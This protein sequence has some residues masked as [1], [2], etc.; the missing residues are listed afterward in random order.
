MPTVI[1]QTF[2]CGKCGGRLNRYK[3]LRGDTH[4]PRCHVGLANATEMRSEAR[5]FEWPRAA[6][7]TAF[8]ALGV[9]LFASQSIPYDTPLLKRIGAIALFLVLPAGWSIVG[10]RYTILSVKADERSPDFR[11]RPP[12]PTGLY[13]A[14]IA[15]V[16]LIVL[17]ILALR[18]SN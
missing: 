17:V 18:S 1:G 9:Y 15:L 6:G 3:L 14:V 5:S 7:A 12:V 8:F 16:L 10:W 2:T 13:I 11:P 4:C